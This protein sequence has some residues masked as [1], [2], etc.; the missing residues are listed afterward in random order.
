MGDDSD[1]SGRPSL[2]SYL[3]TLLPGSAC[4]CCHEELRG[5]G[6]DAFLLSCPRCGCELS[7]SMVHDER[8]DRGGGMSVAA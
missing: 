6:G 8:S 2:S 3:C 7:P 1:L 4:P 5:T